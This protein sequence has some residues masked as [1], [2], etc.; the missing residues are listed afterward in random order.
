MSLLP[1]ETILG[2]LEILEVYEFYDKPCLFSCRNVVGQI[3]LAVWID[4]TSYSDSWLYVPT[5]LRRL[6]QVVGGGI[7]LKN[8]FLEAEDGFVLEVIVFHDGDKAADVLRTSCSNLEEDK[9]PAPDEFLNC[10]SQ[11]VTALI[12]KKDAKRS[13]IQLRR[14]VLNVAF[15]F[16]GFDIMQAPAVELGSLLQSIQYLIDALGQFKAG[17]P[18]IK[19]SIPDRIIQQTKLAVAGTFASSFG[20]EMVAFDKPDLWGNSLAEEAI[21]SF[22][23]LINIGQD[24]ER[25]REFLL[26]AQPRAASRYRIFLE[27]LIHAKARLRADWGSFN[28]EKGDSAELLLV[29]AKIVLGIVSQVESEKPKQYEVEGEL[30]GINKRTKSFEIW[31]IRGEEKK[32]SGRILD[33]ALSVAETATLSR[34]YTSTIMEVTEI[35][36]TGEEKI[37]YQLA[38]LKMKEPRKL[39]RIKSKAL[40]EKH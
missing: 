25:L 28:Q 7:E 38:D 23:Q 2:K 8:A 34:V 36:L 29:D 35:S 22:L 6:Q 9:L 27:K 15:S 24:S 26:D 16:P 13:A 11:I 1:Q 39:S 12:E 17:Q 40:T 10:Q 4:E 32:Y 18:T 3:F 21:E 37:K 33:S 30:V 20:V 19:G 5:S 31:E 14:S